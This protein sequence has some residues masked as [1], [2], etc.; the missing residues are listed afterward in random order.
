MPS[1][2]FS[3]PAKA[4]SKSIE[5]FAAATPAA[6]NAAE[7]GIIFLPAF[8]SLSPISFAFAESCASFW[9]PLPT[10]FSSFC[11]Y[12]SVAMISLCKA[13]YLSC[14]R[15]PASSCFF[16]S[17]SASF[18]CSSFSFTPVIDCCRLLVFC[19][20]SSVFVG[21]NFKSLFTSLSAELVA[22]IFDCTPLNAFCKP[23][24]SPF[25]SI[26]IPFILLAIAPPFFIDCQYLFALRLEGA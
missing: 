7:R 2:V 13:S 17:A 15:L 1:T 8:D 22:L 4:S 25:I 18:N 20:K 3:T 10:V 23:V 14:P 5:D 16:A 6:A 26:V 21:S 11:K 9:L 24:E 12:C 19:R